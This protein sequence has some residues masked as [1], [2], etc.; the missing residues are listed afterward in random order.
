MI[1]VDGIQVTDDDFLDALSEI[2]N[3]CYEFLEENQVRLLLE[4]VAEGSM[5][6]DKALKILMDD[7]DIYLER[8][9]QLER[10]R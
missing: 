10:R 4:Y 2:L 5:S 9:E 6:V 1:E 3:G 8:L 7:R